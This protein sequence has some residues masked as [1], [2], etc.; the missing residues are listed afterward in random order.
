MVIP[1]G[2]PDLV[3]ASVDKRI[4]IWDSRVGIAIQEIKRHSNWVRTIHLLE[5]GNLI[6]SSFDRTICV[7]DSQKG[8][9][10]HKIE[11]VTNVLT[12]AFSNLLDNRFASAT[13]KNICV[14][15]NEGYQLQNKLCGHGGQI[16]FVN[17]TYFFVLLNSFSEKFSEI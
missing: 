3:T 14:Y 8:N 16:W 10:M 11:N 6:S 5:T 9:C 1:I 17:L 13:G 12:C 4:I 7:W 15:D 2:P